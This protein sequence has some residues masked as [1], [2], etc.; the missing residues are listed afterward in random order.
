M[1]ITSQFQSTLPVWGGTPPARSTPG[2]VC[3]FNPPS[4]CGEGLCGY[5]SIAGELAFQSTLP[6]WGGTGPCAELQFMTGKFQST[7]PVWG[8]THSGHPGHWQRP[9]FNPPSPCGEGRERLNVCLKGRNF[10]PPSPCGEGRRN[11]HGAQK[12]D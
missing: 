2:L 7:L 11:L 1:S 8:G 4:P 3:D 6:V 12:S 9:Y 5:G 10:N